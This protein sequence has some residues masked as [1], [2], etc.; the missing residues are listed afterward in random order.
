[1]TEDSQDTI[2]HQR[3]KNT[4]YRVL[5]AEPHEYTLKT[6]LKLPVWNRKPPENVDVDGSDGHEGFECI[7]TAKDGREAIESACRENFDLIITELNLPLLDG[8]Q[9]LKRV[10]TANQPPLV[11]IISDTVTYSYAREGFIC[12]AFDYLPKPVTEEDLDQ[13][14]E[15]AAQELSRLKKEQKKN[16]PLD[17]IHFSSEQLGRF[18]NSFQKKEPSLPESFGRMLRSLYRPEKN[19]GHNPDLLANK[20][21]LTLV[22]KIYEKNDWLNLYL[23]KSFHQKIDYLEPDRPDAYIAFYERKFQ[24]LFDLYCE[25]MPSLQ[26]ETL[27]KVL[28]YL[29]AHPEEDLKLTTVAEIYYLNHT[30]LSNLFS[31]KSPLRYS[32]LVS[33]VKMHRAEYL[34]NYTKEPMEQIAVSLGYKDLPHFQKLY[35]ETIGRSVSDYIRYEEQADDYSI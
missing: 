2:L 11:V 3:R 25:L 27:S 32:R 14:F 17:T 30:Y 33:M 24:S 9:V 29:L 4:V 12:G 6:L 1:M 19:A 34:I 23:P 16:V 15:R 31:R 35:L 7:R 13:L 20:L 28:L 22:E 18:L 10:H 26:D 21:Y 8:L 5:V